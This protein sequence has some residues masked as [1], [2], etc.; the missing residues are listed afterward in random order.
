M[1]AV[2]ESLWFG[3]FKNK[4]LRGF[5]KSLVTV[6]NKNRRR[7]D[8]CVKP[9]SMCKTHDLTMMCTGY[10]SPCRRRTTYRSCSRQVRSVYLHR[11][12]FSTST[13]MNACTLGCLHTVCRRCTTVDNFFDLPSS[14]RKHDRCYS[15]FSNLDKALVLE[16]FQGT[17]RM[18]QNISISCTGVSHTSAFVR[19]LDICYQDPRTVSAMA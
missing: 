13:C 8:S 6:V 10:R 7:L 12:H 1:A 16:C 5:W 3:E 19:N 17:F 9:W 11:T 2:R 4:F 18:I 14:G 15:H